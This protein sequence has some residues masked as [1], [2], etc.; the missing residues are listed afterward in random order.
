MP[1]QNVC[2]TLPTQTGKGLA[3]KVYI[4]IYI[5]RERERENNT[6]NNKIIL[7]YESEQYVEHHYKRQGTSL[8]L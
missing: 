4:Y 5:E 1:H 3:F 2:N 6:Q 8:Y 7:M